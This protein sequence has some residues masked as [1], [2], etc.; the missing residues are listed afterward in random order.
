MPP[1]EKVYLLSVRFLKCCQSPLRSITSPPP[2]P[3]P[4][5]TAKTSCYAP[6]Q[7]S[8]AFFHVHSSFFQ[9]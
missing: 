3:H 2:A 8:G 9:A 6:E 1:I 4:S 7:K 5:D